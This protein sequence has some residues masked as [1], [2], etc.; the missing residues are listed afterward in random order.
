[1]Q[2][3]IAQ[4]VRERLGDEAISELLDGAV[5][6]ETETSYDKLNFHCFNNTFA[7]IDILKV[8]HGKKD[9]MPQD[10]IEYHVN[11]ICGNGRDT[12][13]PEKALAVISENSRKI[14]TFRLVISVENKPSTVNENLKRRMESYIAGLSDLRIDRSDP[15]TELWF[16]YRREGLSLF[17][18]RLTHNVKKNPQPGELPPQLAW[19]LCRSATLRPGEA[20]VDPFCGYGSIPEAALKHFH[21]K[22][23]LA[24]DIDPRCIKITRSKR[25]LQNEHCEIRLADAFSE[26]L[27]EVY[28]DAIIT[29]P[30][31]GMYRE[32]VIPPESFY[33]E[34]LALF[35]RLL[36]PDGRAVVLTGAV[37]AFENAIEKTKRFTVK[38]RIPILVSGKK[39]VV[40]VM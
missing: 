10:A 32:T 4:V 12:R 1:M 36:K 5:I 11:K 19:L 26:P 17:M 28:A 9:A 24:V 8:K 31:W 3:T 20:A 27:P 25:A 7:L 16:L 33:T 13:L 21:I 2:E 23:F 38:K 14:K 34:A 6:Y 40:F 15:D 29:D 18:K 35:S 37:E 30:P 22:K 39:A